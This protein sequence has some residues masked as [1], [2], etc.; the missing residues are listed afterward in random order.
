VRRDGALLATLSGTATSYIDMAPA[1]GTPLYTV[2]PSLGASTAAATSCQATVPPAPVSGL[3]CSLA[4]PCACVAQL[5]WTNAGTYDSLEVR[6]DGVL[7]ATLA[8][9]AMGASV[10]LLGAP[11]ASLCVRAVV[12]GIAGADACCSTGCP[13]V[14]AL[15]I[16]ALS[17]DV[18]D[19]TC[20]ATVSWAANASATAI[21]VRVDGVLVATLPGTA[22]ST[23]VPIGTTSATIEVSG[24]NACGAP[25][26]PS[27]C[28]ALCQP[29]AEFVRGDSN[30]DGAVNISD[31]V[32]TLV[33]LFASGT[34]P[35]LAAL[36]ANDDDTVNLADVIALLAGIFGQGAPPPAPFPGCGADPT[37]GT[38]DCASFPAC[39]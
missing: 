31:P 21:Q 36:D 32:M 22:T 28:A 39:P 17:C 34:V 6:R 26:A 10:A 23:G 12:D 11:P 1:A 2:T 5:A 19:S 18:D 3:S 27:S 7:V 33:Y 16:G 8:G 14:P 24:T 30:A 20:T 9:G 37:A 15:P 25:L 29:P 38:L 35:C 4:D 13:A